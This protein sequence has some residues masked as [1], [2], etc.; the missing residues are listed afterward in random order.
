MAII[1]HKHGMVSENPSVRLILEAFRKH[2]IEAN[3][4]VDLKHEHEKAMNCLSEGRDVLAVM[5]TG[6]GKRFIY[7]FN[8]L[9]LQ[10][11]KVRKRNL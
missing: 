2:S 7:I 6:Y 3:D 9:Q 5:P 10:I 4:L 1:K 11:K 8:C